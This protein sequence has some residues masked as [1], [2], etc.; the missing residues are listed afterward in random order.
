[1]FTS[2]PKEEAEP[3][4]LAREPLRVVCAWCGTIIQGGPPH[5]ISHGMCAECEKAEYVKMENDRWRDKQTVQITTKDVKR[6]V[7]RCLICQIC[8]ERRA[9][10]MFY[11]LSPDVPRVGMCGPCI[12]DCLD[13]GEAERISPF[14]FREKKGA[15]KW[16][17]GQL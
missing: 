13:R 7:H 15:P 4:D 2:S 14:A 8:E 1:L 5:P 6:D 11:S 12:A 9:D 17:G 3:E 16:K 10:F